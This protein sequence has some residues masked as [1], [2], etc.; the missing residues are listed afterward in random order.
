MAGSAVV[1]TTAV[2][3]EVIAGVVMF[4]GADVSTGAGCSVVTGMVTGRT[5]VTGAVIDSIASA[6]V[7]SGVVSDTV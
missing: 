5:V 1:W 3:T 2:W 6:I 7:G 4:T